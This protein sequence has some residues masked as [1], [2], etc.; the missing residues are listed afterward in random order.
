MPRRTALDTIFDNEN[1]LGGEDLL[2]AGDIST[3]DSL[4]D[5][6]DYNQFREGNAGD[7]GNDGIDAPEIEGMDDEDYQNAIGA[8]IDNAEQYIDTYISPDRENAARYYRGEKFGNE[9]EGRSGVVMSEVRDTV[10]ALMP[11]LLR[12]FCG[13]K[14]PVEFTNQP[15]TPFEQGQQQTA[16][17]S[18]IINKD[19][20]GFMIHFSAFKDALVRRTG[21]Y[22]WWHEAIELVTHEDKTGL[23]EEAYALEQLEVQESSSED[24]NI[25]Y[26]IEVLDERLDTTAPAADPLQG[27]GPEGLEMGQ[28]PAPQPESYIR[29]IRV[30]RRFIKKRHRV[31]CVPPE[32]FIV[33]P[34][35]SD[36]LDEFPLVGRRQMKSIGELVAMGHDEAQIREAIGGTG[37]RASA[38]EMNAE[39]LDRNGAPLERIFDNDFAQVDPASEYVKY[40]TVFVLIDKDGDGIRERRKICTVGDNN[41]IIYDTISDDMVPYSLICP[42]PEPH[43]PFGYSVADQ[44]MDMQEVTSEVVRGILDNLAQSIVGRTA[45]LENK[46]NIDDVLSNDRDQVIREKESGAVRSL[47]H[48]FTGMNASARASTRAL[49]GACRQTCC[50]APPASPP[51][52]WSIRLRSGLR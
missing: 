24:E 17:I 7:L 4:A 10:L 40:C 32:E 3:I 48:P 38:L 37:T 19:N 49:R 8:A 52:R 9:I 46:V 31:A 13:A 44:N 27:M 43:A 12:I 51:N 18:H 47:S 25:Q 28:E 22:T 14:E 35:A 33:S 15:G 45:I 16:F 34:I 50:K 42:D 26:D 36:D 5:D 41:I 1:S 11:A 21:I 2:A 6:E 20:N 29:D 39:A 30:K 23:N